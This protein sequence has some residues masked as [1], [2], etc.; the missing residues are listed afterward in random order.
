MGSLGLR[1]GRGIRGR[2][3]NRM[4][5]SNDTW[6]A[7]DGCIWLGDVGIDETIMSLE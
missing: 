7:W 1:G 2:G 3:G 4:A 6:Y 5:F